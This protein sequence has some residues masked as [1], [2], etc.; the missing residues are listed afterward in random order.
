ML[1]LT[2]TQLAGGKLLSEKQPRVRVFE[3]DQFYSAKE[4]AKKLGGRTH[5]ITIFNWAK[6]GRITAHK[7]SANTTRFLGS[8][9]NQKLFPSD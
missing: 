8:E 9:L 1:Q 5:P 3:D 6:Q 2:N 7:I 4:V